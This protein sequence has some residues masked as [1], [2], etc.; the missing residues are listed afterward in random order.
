MSI[1]DL[2]GIAQQF[3]DKILYEDLELHLNKG[4]ILPDRTKWRRKKYLIKIITGEQRMKHDRLAKKSR[5]YWIR[6]E[7]DRRY[8]FEL[9]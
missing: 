8:R 2:T 3:G 5:G 6:C 4:N 1:L 9:F 7:V